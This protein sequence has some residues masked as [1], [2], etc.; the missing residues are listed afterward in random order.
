MAQKRNI[1]PK[2]TETTHTSH[3]TD[4][5]EEVTLEQA[6]QEENEVGSDTASDTSAATEAGNTTSSKPAKSKDKP[7]PDLGFT[8][9]VE[10]GEA[11]KLSAKSQGRIFYQIAKKDDENRLY[12]RIDSNEGGGLHSREW[13]PL[14]SVIELLSAQK[15]KDFSS[16]IFKAVVVGKSS[17][18][19]SFLAGI[20]RSKDIA[21]I[22]QSPEGIFLQRLVDNF[23]EQAKRILAL[24]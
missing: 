24:G 10:K 19:V 22:Q 2:T 6:L 8:F 21:L 16:P 14:D 20:L 12:V 11:Q 17:N 15:G 5:S 4:L 18:N 1:T 7:D 23:D 3:E 9:I 13:I